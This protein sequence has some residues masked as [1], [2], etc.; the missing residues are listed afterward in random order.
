ML[1]VVGFVKQITRSL[2]GGNRVVV[3]FYSLSCLVCT[4]KEMLLATTLKPLSR[5]KTQGKEEDKTPVFL[6][7]KAF[8][9]PLLL[10][11]VSVRVST[12]RECDAS[13]SFFWE[14]SMKKL[15]CCC[16]MRTMQLQECP[17][18]SL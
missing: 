5:Q 10:L 9:S 7:A 12:C 6:L 8:L 1:A 4:Q 18:G 17:M 14:K 16:V 13:N 2:L 11:R 15:D 3:T